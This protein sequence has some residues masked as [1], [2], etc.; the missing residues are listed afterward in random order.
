MAQMAPWLIIL[1]VLL[2]C[3]LFAVTIAGLGKMY[4]GDTSTTVDSKPSDAQASYM[5]EV[6]AR[7]QIAIMHKMPRAHMQRSYTNYTDYSSATGAC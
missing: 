3:A 6:R 4:Y 7:N 1:L 2:G 5:R